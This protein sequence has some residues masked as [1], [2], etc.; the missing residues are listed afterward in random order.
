ML[1]FPEE[2]VSL[3]GDSVFKGLVNPAVTSVQCSVGNA[4]RTSCLLWNGVAHR[5]GSS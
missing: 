2:D 4:R 3:D 1:V 5:S